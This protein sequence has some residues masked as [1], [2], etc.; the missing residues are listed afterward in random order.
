MSPRPA[1]AGMVISGTFCC[2]LLKSTGPLPRAPAGYSPYS[3]H[4]SETALS[5]SRRD[6]SWR[7]SLAPVRDCVCNGLLDP[8][9]TAR[10]SGP[11]SDNEVGGDT[12]RRKRGAAKPTMVLGDTPEEG[13]EGD[14]APPRSAGSLALSSGGSGEGS[15]PTLTKTP[16]HNASRMPPPPPGGRPRRHGFCLPGVSFTVG[17]LERGTSSRAESELEDGAEDRT[18][19]LT[20][21]SASS[22]GHELLEDALWADAAGNTKSNRG[23]GKDTG[24]NS[25]V[26]YIN[27]VSANSGMPKLLQASLSSSSSQM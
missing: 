18:V 11:P 23:V 19:L 21:S 7:S 12:R 10:N 5:S 27:G 1:A 15:L 16:D 6:M 3:T 2:K 24:R 20:S 4:P 9:S 26:A 13:E 8:G 17:E 25:V 22:S 14:D